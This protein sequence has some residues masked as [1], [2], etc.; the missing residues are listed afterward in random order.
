MNS[1]RHAHGI[2]EERGQAAVEFAMVVP[3]LLV[4]LL[5]IV[6][7][8]IVYTHYLTIT[9]AARAGARRA[10]VARVAGLSSSDITTAVQNAAA[11]LDKS[12][13]GITVSD[14]TDPTFSKAGSDI[15]VTVTYPYSIN[16]LGWVVQSGN[17][18]TTITDRLE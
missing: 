9:D 4:L 2:R 10:I 11:D 17:L 5:G 7:G 12:Q 15:T 6:Q 16:V 13:L 1:R 8:G 18:T 14:P 3:I